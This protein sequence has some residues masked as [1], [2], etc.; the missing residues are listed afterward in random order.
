MSF[1]AG[2]SAYEAFEVPRPIPIEE[3]LA[4]FP[5]FA[6]ES[7]NTIYYA[8]TEADRQ[9]PAQIW[10]DWRRDGYFYLAAH[11][12]AARTQAIGSM[13]GAPPGPNIGTGLNS[14]LYGQARQRLVDSLPIAGF[15][16]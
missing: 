5:E 10:G 1:Q 11:L 16:Y 8:L 13:I 6:T 12:L 7:P 3:F 2:N 4:R 15:T 14:T 9:T